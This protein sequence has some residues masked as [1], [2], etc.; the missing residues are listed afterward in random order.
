MNQRFQTVQNKFVN[1]LKT[2]GGKKLEF[3]KNLSQKCNFR[4]RQSPCLDTLT[5]V[6]NKEGLFHLSVVFVSAI[7]A[8][9]IFKDDKSDN[10]LIQES[11]LTLND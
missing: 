7:I 1:L 2:L 8:I 6:K 5:Q 11:I 4:L 9:S 10:H 3:G